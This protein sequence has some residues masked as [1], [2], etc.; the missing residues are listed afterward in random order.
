MNLQNNFEYD[1]GRDAT[2]SN[3]ATQTIHL[4]FL[5]PISMSRAESYEQCTGMSPK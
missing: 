3:V 5:F 1:S 4:T 2:S